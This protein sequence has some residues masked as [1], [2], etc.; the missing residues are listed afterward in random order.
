MTARL[1]LCLLSL[2]LHV[3]AATPPGFVR[4]LRSLEQR[5]GGRI[6]VAVLEPGRGLRLAYRAQERFPLCST[7]KL[8]EVGLVLQRVDAGT[9]RLERRI[10]LHRADLL[11]HSPVC[12]ARVGEGTLKVGELC[13]AAIT[14]SDNAAGNLLLEGL[15][16]PQ[17]LTAGLRHLGDGVT[18]LDRRE[19]DLN[20]NRP[21]DPRD[22]TTPEAMARSASRLIEGPVLTPASRRRLRAWM[23]GCTTGGNRLR[24]GLPSSWR[25]LDKTGTGPRGA[26]NDVALV[27]RPGSPTLLLAVYTSGGRGDLAEQEAVLVA[28]ARLVAAEL[29]P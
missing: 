23:A 20:E 24:A 16:G 22:T 2:S 13:E 4:A 27:E 5:R 12:S 8:L 14:V 19:P 21:G 17:G 26:V 3:F 25:V 28:V 9:E 10:P 7:F 11:P 15:G 18:R 29:G 1:F 6:G